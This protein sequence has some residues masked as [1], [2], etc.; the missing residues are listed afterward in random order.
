MILDFPGGVCPN[1]RTLFS[2]QQIKKIESC[3]A[4]CI[5]ADA[6][7]E[8]SVEVGSEVKRGNLLGMSGGTP[9]YA[10]VA[11]RFS[12]VLDIEGEK[13]FVVMNNGEEGEER[14]CPPETIAINE[15]TREYIIE[16]AK[17]FAVIDSRSGM[18]LWK[19]I[20]AGPKFR[21]VVI[22]CT[23]SDPLSACNFRICIENAKNIVNGAKI[24]L[25]ATG[26]L[27]C[28]FAAEHNRGMIFDAL[29][30]F[31]NDKKLFA[32]APLAEKYPYGDRALMHA[33]YLRT[34][35]K[36]E[37]ALD[38]NVLIVSP[39][40]ALSLYESM[41]T[42][43]PRTHKLLAYV[44]EGI[45]GGGSLLVPRGM[46]MH[47]ITAICGNAPEGCLLIENSLLCGKPMGGV[48]RDGTQAVISVRPTEKPRSNC[49]S[50]GECANA[51]P[52]RLFPFEALGRGIKH[53]QKSCISCG[54]CNFICPSGIPLLELIWRDLSKKEATE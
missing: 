43:M 22:D 51:C 40:T 29:G 39:E 24:L 46:T 45:F 28:V 27:K 21:R 33:L 12:G 3:S 53:L 32:M 35:A 41:A 4:I 18:P 37:T 44:G 10:S 6:D 13:Y 11:G 14:L 26:A 54:A 25:Q 34:L 50:C 2:E 42:G 30:E 31:A 52:V 17:K 47:D 49:I 9:V 23:E 15:M 1:E 19:L 5:K 20:E 38:K 16:S 8:I 48:L 36:D 7:A